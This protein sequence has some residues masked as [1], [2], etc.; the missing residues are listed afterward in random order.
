MKRLL[1]IFLTVVFPGLGAAQSNG[2]V[3][4]NPIPQPNWLHGCTMIDDGTALAVGDV[5]TIIRSTNSGETWTVQ[6]MSQAGPTRR[7]LWSVDL[8]AQGF[9]VA[10]GERGMIYCTTDAGQTWTHTPGGTISRLWS[11]SILD[12]RTA[13]AVGDNGTIVFTANAGASCR[14]RAY[15][16]K[17]RCDTF[18]KHSHLWPI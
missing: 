9:G 16:W 12:S 11:V 5:G 14:I 18:E 7:D 15:R 10:V 6:H 2:W 4:R 13:C 1:I 17:I 3:W 8:C